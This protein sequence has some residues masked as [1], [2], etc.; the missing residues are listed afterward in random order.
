MKALGFQLL[1]L[2]ESKVAFNVLGSTANLHPYVEVPGIRAGRKY[3]FEMTS[4]HNGG[5]E[6]APGSTLDYILKARP[7]FNFSISQT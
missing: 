4:P 3:R 7:G 2:F 1:E 5:A 6:E